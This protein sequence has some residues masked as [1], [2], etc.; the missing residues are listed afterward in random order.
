MHFDAVNCDG[1]KPALICGSSNNRE[2]YYLP[3]FAI[4]H[5]NL[6]NWRLNLSGNIECLIRGIE[7]QEMSL[8][9]LA[10]RSIAQHKIIYRGLIPKDLESFIQLH[11]ASKL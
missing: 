5:N 11:S 1:L 4:V 10:S 9:C 7:T 2:H 6:L 3:H 8:K